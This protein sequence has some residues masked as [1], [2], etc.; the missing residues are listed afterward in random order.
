MA[1]ITGYGLGSIP[2]GL[3]LTRLGGAGDLQQIGSGNI[4]AT[5]VLRT[6]R[7]DLAAA[8]LCFD[9][10]KGA[11]AVWIG[12]RVVDGGGALAGATA[13]IGHCYSIWL[14]FAGGKGVST[15]MGLV[16]ALHWPVG[17][18]FA[19]VW[20]GVLFVTR[21]SSLGGMSAAASAPVAMWLHRANIRR[22]LSGTEPKVG[23][24]TA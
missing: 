19:L 3:I 9:L 13:F 15:M 10:L 4:G 12:A 6:G 23:Q 24:R 16:L 5:N 14:R 11:V 2:F 22:L 18:V 20:L 21:W 17:I 1:T 7:M 8:T